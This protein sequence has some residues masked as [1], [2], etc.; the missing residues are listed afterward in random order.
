MAKYTRGQVCGVDN[1]PSQLWQRINGR[2]VCQYGHVNEFDIEI[3]DEDEIMTNANG[4]GSKDHSRR[5]DNVAG[6]TTSTAVRNKLL[7]ISKDRMITRKYG[8]DFKKLQ[9]RCYQIILSKNTQFIINELK[10]SPYES[11]HYMATVKKHWIKLLSLSINKALDGN[12]KTYKLSQV[13]M[14]NYLSLIEMNLPIYL[15]DFINLTYNKK[16]NLLRCEYCLPKELRLQIPIS[17]IK[18]FHGFLTINYFSQL[19]KRNFYKSY[20]MSMSNNKLNYYPLLIKILLRLYLPL[21]IGKVVNNYIVKQNISFNY[22]EMYQDGL[23]PELKL[24]SIITILANVYFRQ[25]SNREQFIE[26]WYRYNKFKDLEETG[27]IGLK[28]RLFDRDISFG[29]LMKWSDNQIMQ[30]VEFY[31]RDMLRN[32]NANNIATNNEYKDR[33]SLKLAK[34]LT[35]L[36]PPLPT[37]AATEPNGESLDKTVTFLHEVYDSRPVTETPT[38]PDLSPPSNAVLHAVI[39]YT[40]TVYHCTP[41]EVEMAVL[42]VQTI[43]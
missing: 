40:T 1:C 3:N 39:I 20:I 27:F 22:N 18:S 26:W 14:I 43:T 12:N 13:L 5:L 17:Q 31:E 8:E 34:S 16:F 4:V 10:L 25:P 41:M 42:K 15:C 24:I 9:A 23:H 32:I 33:S 6:L 35:D 38:K 7:Q 30:Y 37:D 36:F 29:K 19:L 28:Q 2:N 11:K 21:E